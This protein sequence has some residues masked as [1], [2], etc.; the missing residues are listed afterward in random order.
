MDEHLA[1][2][3]TA[4]CRLDPKTKAKK[5]RQKKKKNRSERETRRERTRGMSLCWTEGALNPTI[6]NERRVKWSRCK[7]FGSVYDGFFNNT[8]R[9]VH[10][11][12]ICRSTKEKW[13]HFAP[14]T[15][16]STYPVVRR[17]P[18]HAP[19]LEPARTLSCF[20]TFSIDRRSG[21]RRLARNRA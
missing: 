11:I 5:M 13:N 9:C 4:S 18:Q 16:P 15:I 3:S 20:V 2:L 12:V 10:S 19:N 1:M 6:I 21:R 8:L 14:K 17:S 7:V